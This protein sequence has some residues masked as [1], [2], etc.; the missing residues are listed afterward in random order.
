MR[1]SA[2]LAK[3][4]LRVARPTDD[5]DAVMAMAPEFGDRMCGLPIGESRHDEQVYGFAGHDSWV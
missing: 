3:A 1:D 2:M 5:L 4:H